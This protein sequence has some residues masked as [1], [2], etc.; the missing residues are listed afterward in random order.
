MQR[1]IKVNAESSYK[2]RPTP[3]IKIKGNYLIEH[4][5]DIDTV[6]NIEIE[7]NKII[8]TPMK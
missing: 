4:G 3:T 7:N 8:I 6:L 1:K 2:Y 5:F